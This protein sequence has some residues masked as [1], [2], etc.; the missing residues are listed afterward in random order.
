[1]KQFNTSYTVSANKFLGCI[2]NTRTFFLVAFLLVASVASA[3]FDT[4]FIRQGT[5]YRSVKSGFPFVDTINY[6]W[7]N[8]TANAKN[9]KATVTLPLN[10][11]PS[12]TTFSKAVA[13]DPSQI[14][15]VAYNAGSNI[16][17]ITFVNPLPAGS[18][19]QLTLSLMYVNGTTPNGYAPNI[20]TSINADNNL[21]IDSVANGPSLDTVSVT[22]I[23]ANTFYVNKTVKAGGAINDATIYTLN[24]GENGGGVGSLNLT[25]PVF[26]DTL[27]VGAQFLSATP[28]NG[29]YAPVYNASNNTITWTWGTKG[30]D[31][32]FSGYSSTAYISVNYPN[33]AF[34][35]GD[36]VCNHATLSGTIPVL[37]IGTYAPASASGSVCE[38]LA[39]PSAGA[40]CN[41]G[42]ITAATAYWLNHHILAGTT[43]NWFGEGWYNSGNTSLSEVDLSYTI[44]KSV[45]FTT[46]NVK[47]VYDGFDSAA[48]A[49]IQVSYTTNL[50]PSKLLGTY[51][52]LDIAS[53]KTSS[54]FTPTMGTGEY[55][56]KVDFKVTGTL[57]IGGYEDFSYC[58]NTR[59]AAQGAKDGSPIVEGA[60]KFPVGSDGGTVV[61]NKSAGSYT[62]NGI[63]TFY[64]PC[65]DSS[66]IIYAQPA[67][68]DSY[69]SILNGNSFDASDTVNYQFHTYLGGNLNATTVTVSDTL[70][71]RL[72][73]IAG[74]STYTIGKGIAS[75]ITPDT[76]RTTDGTKR[77]ILTYK[78]GT[79]T[80]GSDYYINLNAEINPGTLPGSIANRFNLTSNNALFTTTTDT[81]NLTILS[82]VALR[83]YKGQSGCDPGYIYYPNVALAQAGGP[84]NYK[85]T[86][87]NLGN[88]AANNLVLVDVFPFR[89]D[90][91]TSQWYANLSSTVSIS[92]ASSK[93]YYTT[94]TNPCYTDFNPAT[95][96]SGCTTPSWSTTPPTNLTTVTAIKVTRATAIPVLDSIVLSWPMVAPVGVP[97]GL[98]MNNSLTYQVSRADNGSQLLPATPMKVGM[99]TNCTPV[100][101][102]IGNYV[103]IDSNR[104]GLQDEPASLG[105]NGVRVF[106]YENTG[107]GFVK[108]DSSITANDWSGNPGYYEFVNLQSG[109]YYVNF[110][111]AYNGDT[112]TKVVNQAPQVDGNSDAN[113]VT[114]NS[115]IV[116]INTSGT[117]QD[118]NNTT[119]DAGYVPY[120]SIGNYVWYDANGNG[121]QD[122]GNANGINGLKVYLYELINNVYTRI[123]STVTAN[124][125][126]KPGYYNFV[127]DSSG[128]YKVLFPTT[129]GTKVLTI[130]DTTK[131][132][133]GNSDAY[134]NTGFSEVVVM[135]N[136]VKSGTNKNNSTIDAGYRCNTQQP[137]IAASNSN[138]CAGYGSV[139]TITTDTTILPKYQWYQNGV[140]I[141][142][143]TKDSLLTTLAGNSPTP[144]GNY[145]LVVT[146]TGGC[147]SPSSAAV[148]ISIPAAPATPTITAAGPTTFCSGNSLA[149]KSSIAST[150]QW[151]RNGAIIAGATNQ[152]Y[153]ADSAG[154]YTVI[155][156]NTYGCVSAASAAT[157]LT[158]FV[159][160]A[161]AAPTLTSVPQY[162]NNTVIL[163][164]TASSA[165][166]WY[167]NG[168]AISGADSQTYKP[169]VTGN[170]SVVQTTNKGC[171]SA[172]SPITYAF[173]NVTPTPIIVTTGTP[174]LCG[175]SSVQLNCA[176]SPNASI[177]GYSTYQWYLN[178]TEIPGATN[179]S[180]TTSTPGNYTV[181]ATIGT[182]CLSA[183]SASIIVSNVPAPG[184]PTIVGSSLV[185]SGTPATLTSSSA[186]NNQWY[187]NGSPISGATGQTY[188]ATSLGDYKVVV[189]NGNCSAT[190]AIDTLRSAVTANFTFAA[191]TVSNT[192]CLTGNSISYTNTSLGA[193][194]YKWYTSDSMVS[195]NSNTKDSTFTTANTYYVKLVASNNSGC[196]D[197][198][199]QPIYIYSC[200]VSS[201]STGGLES[202][203][204]GAAIGTRN[205]NLYKNSK[206][207]VVQYTDEQKIIAHK[208]SAYGMFGSSSSVSLA[209]LMPYQVNSSYIAYDQSNS[210]SDL[211]SITNAVD[212]RAIDFTLNNSPK[213]V[214]FATKT[215]GGIYSHTKPICDRLKGAQLLDISNVSIK[216]FTF[217]QYKIMQPNGDLEFAISFSAGQKAG[218]S[219]MS[220]QSNW[221]MPHYI[222][223]D[224]MFN[225]QLWAANPVDVA[226]MVS[227]VLTKLQ[228]NKTLAQLND[229]DLPSAYVSAASRQGTNLSL[230]VNNRTGNTSGF[231]QLAKRST[232]NN[233][234]TDTV[235]IPFT[236]SANA[237][238][239]VTIPVSDT[240]DANISMLFNNNTTD[241][242]YMA[243]GIWG[244]SGDNSTVVSQFKVIN[245]SNK[246]YASNEYPLLRDV[247]V[248]VTTPSYLTI[249]KYLKGAAAS[250]DLSTYKSFHFTTA[251]NAEGLNLKVTITK[252]SVGIWSSQY[253][254]TI[255]N[256]Q[257]GQTYEI[258]LSD[259]KSTDGNLPATL[260]A[261]DITS[262]VY[263]LVNTT[264]QSLNIKAGISNAA[265]STKDIAYE[266]TLQ[267]KT[268]SVSPNPNNGN[269]KVSFSSPLNTSLRL[270]VVDM[271][272]RIISSKMIDAVVGKN[273]VSVG[274][275]MATKGGIYFISL[276]GAGTK[277][278]SQKMI[279]K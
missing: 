68:H 32:S 186:I 171:I 14:S 228:E 58:G 57:P 48:P 230:T 154:N 198:I 97:S 72:T 224:T 216:N 117:G 241:M 187:Q 148:T 4:L 157:T 226:S 155:T 220:I 257:D 87:K 180:Y 89:N 111:I 10:L 129:I 139:L 16:V 158:I 63:T 82:A 100:G 207:G 116:T 238:T 8:F 83:A 2:A 59:T 258:A 80:P 50:Y 56:T 39:S 3:Q 130:Q 27:P 274:V 190:S 91:R 278:D 247:Q 94:V 268:V 244:T 182:G 242:L 266:R 165:Y 161:P 223:E 203:S 263:N 77:L 25:N 76:S 104:N 205:Y 227:E 192:P 103:W 208:K 199:T 219:T 166:Q 92:D 23:A 53:G 79:L 12:N 138:L 246:E 131:A 153:N 42:G 229:N 134:A 218:R 255:N 17:T 210:V 265:F 214:A 168:V 6:S 119:I 236:I 249:Y 55:I 121:L 232:E 206:N 175:G 29:S 66:E 34:N 184:T 70:D 237:K 233:E 93:V 96:P 144:A 271:T 30:V 213:A 33:T 22:A 145:T 188:T 45:D 101:G 112:L 51:Q 146:D 179:L 69:K 85:I 133:D 18:T 35:L 60:Y 115:G 159:T 252:L 90:Y 152:T 173:V 225:Y 81:V 195:T 36:N 240:Y 122:D 43:C 194:S 272:G 170:Y 126:G 67:F 260:D 114:G 113:I 47:P 251:T 19:G 135:N 177:G 250:V 254:Y 142:G 151:Y 201:G 71:N 75:A 44:D 149:L 262:V 231:F 136:L 256:L 95:N 132:K 73:Y 215:I 277:Y 276:Q 211:E 200:A 185:C 191:T 102:S 239:T 156:S 234:A 279:I 209:S 164:T 106:L 172:Q 174:Q 193:T 9:A 269:F 202:K 150:Y 197:S 52:S 99:T 24:I 204:L 54:S 143:A 11:V 110:P 38:A 259:F 84:V 243:D 74:S 147:A 140:A 28:F 108:V 41:G 107:S 7:S 65:I 163:S 46:I 141:T 221:L 49:S 248:Q 120:G 105:M 5:N 124:S 20:I 261:S 270:A 37:P 264:G 176:S 40:D 62:Y 212:V 183:P 167:L 109:Q 13:Y 118:L 178:G 88:V 86:L 160:P 125:G 78:L 64:N 98:L 26:I 181:V 162:C 15:A 217:I 31:T 235:L 267:V 1:M 222:S 21:N 169:Q 123:D 273:E 127:I 275:G 189:T 61:Y 128:L 196:S 253:S 245:N 137:V